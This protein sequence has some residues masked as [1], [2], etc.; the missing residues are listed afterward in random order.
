MKY[1]LLALILVSAKAQSADFRFINIGEN[2]SEINSYEAS[3]GSK[4][5][6]GSR[7]SYKF[8]GVFLNK[9]V[10]INYECENNIFKR[11][12][13]DLYFDSFLDARDFYLLN[14]ETVISM[15]GQPTMDNGSPKYVKAMK[16]IGFEVG[17]KEKYMISW[18]KNEK[19]SWFGVTEYSLKKNKVLL[20]FY[21][22]HKK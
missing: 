20:Q 6:A 13:Y 15:L 14:K 12:F 8:I 11:G 21:V 22:S 2:C 4:V 9:D 17:E 5:S 7:E 10:I 3:V 1:I 18:V 16:A 19:S